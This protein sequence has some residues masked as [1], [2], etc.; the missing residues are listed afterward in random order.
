MY[1]S[2]YMY[3]DKHSTD[4]CDINVLVFSIITLYFLSFD[5]ELNHFFNFSDVL[6]NLVIESSH[7]YKFSDFYIILF[8][9]DIFDIFDL[10]NF[11]EPK[12]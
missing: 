8:S 6:P 2:I 9:L 7:T 1:I 4:L 10:F 3:F 5:S 11:A 12:S